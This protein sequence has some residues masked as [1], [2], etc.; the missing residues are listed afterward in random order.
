MDAGS[1]LRERLRPDAL[2]M[3]SV[4]AIRAAREAEFGEPQDGPANGTAF[5]LDSL[6][7]H[8]EVETLRRLYGAAFIAVGV[9]TP[10]RVRLEAVEKR[11]RDT[12]GHGNPDDFR[13]DAERLME[14]D[15]DEQERSFGQHVSDAFALA[16][17]VVSTAGN[18]SSSIER[19]VRLLFGDWT[20]TPTR[21][22]VGMTH[23][24]VS[25]Y[26]SSS[27]ARQVGAAICR[28][29]GTLVA[30]GTNDVPKS[31]GGIFDADDVA[32][33]RPDVR[34]FSA[35]GYDTSDDHRRELL[36]DILVRLIQTDVVTSISEDGAQIA[37]Q[38]ML[39]R[40]GVMRR[41]KF[42]A[43]ID[44]VRAMHAEAAALSSAASYGDAVRGCTL[45]VTT[46][47]C[48]DCTKDII[49]SGIHR[50][51]YVEPYTKSLAQVFYDKQINVDGS[52]SYDQAVK[53]EPFVG[54]APRR[55]RELF[56]MAG[57][58]KDDLGRYRPWDKD[59]AIPR[60]PET[61]AGASARSAGE[62]AELTAFDELLE[63]NSL[64]PL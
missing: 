36:Q 53:F 63:Q 9:Y 37:A 7:H 59:E 25:A 24:L 8:E 22:E 58:R 57:N 46:F 31:G 38:A 50:V 62:K 1:I 18:E 64:R 12:A 48:H 47:P 5:I 2:A 34:D 10:Y 35:F 61:L 11:L 13:H 21:D 49:A 29:D 23:A 54:V 40:G 32:A 39:G 17:V 55:Y 28:E 3:F 41:A 26:R 30:T 60:L 51:V 44:Y 16:D 27:M 15:R 45:Y 6:K 19:F 43:T 42:M 56:A 14:K 52:N 4:N 20:K 33:K